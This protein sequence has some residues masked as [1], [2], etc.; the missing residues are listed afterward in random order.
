MEKAE[1]LEPNN[2]SVIAKLGELRR[3]VGDFDGKMEFMMNEI[4]DKSYSNHFFIV[5]F[6]LKKKNSFRCLER[7]RK[8]CFSSSSSFSSYSSFSQL[9]FFFSVSCFYF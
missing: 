7:L 3:V 6:F 1:R 2:V 9:Y 5:L 4:E 8:V